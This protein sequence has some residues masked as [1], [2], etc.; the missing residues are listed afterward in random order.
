M[1]DVQTARGAAQAPGGEG[2]WLARGAAAFAARRARRPNRVQYQPYGLFL[3]EDGGIALGNRLAA[4]LFD[5]RA[6]TAYS[7]EDE[8]VFCSPSKGTPFDVA[9]YSS[10]LKLAL[11]T[12]GITRPMRP[13]HDGRH[14]SITN[15]AAAGL[16]PAALMSRAGHSDFKTTQGYIDLAGEAFRNEAALVEQRIFGPELGTQ[17]GTHLS[18]SQPVPAD[19]SPHSDAASDP[20]ATPKT[21][22]Q[23]R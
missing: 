1:P 17:V 18:E 2:I 5:H 21:D 22:L 23:N 10:T 9:R 13:F 6:R 16:S 4:E 7:G 12:A 3:S 19:P 15:S 14:T 8:R 11:K 20:I